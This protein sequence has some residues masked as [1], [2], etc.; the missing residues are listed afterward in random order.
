MT[1]DGG[2]WTVFY[3]RIDGSE[4]FSSSTISQ[5]QTIG[6]GSVETST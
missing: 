6:V 4:D 5:L 2:G 1:T 3:R